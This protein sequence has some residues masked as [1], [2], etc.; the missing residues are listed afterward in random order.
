MK[1]III[2]PSRLQATRLPNKPL[3]LLNGVPL[4]A[5]VVRRAKESNVADILVAASNQEIIDVLAPYN[6][7]AILTDPNLPSGSDRIQQALDK[8]DKAKKYDTIINL[9]GD[10]PTINKECIEGALNALTAGDYD[11]TTI[12]AAINN[13]ADKNNPNI[14]KVA[15]SFFDNNIG[16]ALY[17]SRAPIPWGKGTMYHHIGLYVYKREALAKFTQLAPSPLEKQEKLEQLRAL[18]NNMNI[19][20]KVVN[21]IPIGVDT[22]EEL[23]KAEKYLQQHK[24]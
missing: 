16:K 8:F 2:I 21:T 3:A 12:G 14:V 19:G 13:E 20:F 22:L 17:F 5:H 10:L 7:Q 9:Q 4:I 23:Q 1:P 15:V 24:I 6:I 18:E 11:L